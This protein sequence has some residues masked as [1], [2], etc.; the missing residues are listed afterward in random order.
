[1]HKINT[2]TQNVQNKK[3]KIKK[4]LKIKRIYSF[5]SWHYNPIGG[6][7]SQPSRGL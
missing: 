7:I 1:M 4:K 5:F 2:K 3:P 6:C